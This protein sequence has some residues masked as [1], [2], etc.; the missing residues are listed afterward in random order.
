MGMNY[1]L[2]G[3]HYP[4][5]ELAAVIRPGM[6]VFDIGANRGQ[7]SLLFAKLV[8]PL[9]RVAAFEPVEELAQQLRR[10]VALN[11][12][13][14]V[15]VFSVALGQDD[16]Q[17]AF[18]FH[19]SAST[20]GHLSAS[21]RK[22]GSGEVRTVEVRALDGVPNLPSPDLLKIDVEG[23]AFEVMLGA[24]ET[25]AAARPI[26]YLELHGAREREAVSWLQAEL[27]Y[28]IETD[29]R[30]PLQTVNECSGNVV[31]LIP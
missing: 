12:F 2:G 5:R 26:I 22:T 11:T 7:L 18:A 24:R 25:L 10:N 16:G 6:R 8:G 20:Q 13:S 28:K 17:A 23:A 30:Q 1:W 14:H 21:D 19:A 3:S 29:R 27:A 15:D 9:G 31:W 4:L